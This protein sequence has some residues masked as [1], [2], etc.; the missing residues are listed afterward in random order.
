ASFAWGGYEGPM[1]PTEL[2]RWVG[3][4]VGLVG[5]G[6]LGFFLVGRPIVARW[7]I[8]TAVVV[9]GVSFLA[10][11]AGPILLGPSSP[12]GPLLGICFTG[13]LGVVVGAVIG[14]CIG[15]TKERRLHT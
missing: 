8:T 1:W 9:G 7:T 13:P 11:V 5:G 6:G 2:G 10:G 4:A 3:V 12:Q 15:V 14:L